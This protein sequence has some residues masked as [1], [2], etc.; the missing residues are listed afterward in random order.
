MHIFSNTEWEHV[1]RKWAAG[2]GFG[3]GHIPVKVSAEQ[4]PVFHNITAY[5]LASFQWSAG[6]GRLPNDCSDAH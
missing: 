4:N 3:L 1:G 2:C 5:P 6:S